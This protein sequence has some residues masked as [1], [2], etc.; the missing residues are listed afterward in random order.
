MVVDFLIIPYMAILAAEAGGS[1]W[2]AHY[3]N[4]KGATGDDG[5]D[6]GGVMPFDLTWLPE[7]FFSLGFVYALWPLVGWW[8]LIALPWCY[9]WMQTGHANA[10]PW[11]RGGHDPDRTNTLSPI[12]KWLCDA[13]NIKYYG[14]NFARLFMA[15]KGFLITLPVGG[16]SGFIFW[17]LGY[18]I[19]NRI[20]KHV[21]AELFSGAGAGISILLFLI[22]S[23]WCL[24]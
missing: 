1:L 12:V 22:I 17:P 16:F 21:Y 20:G 6:L 5:R 9:I 18:E 10:L 4:K 7:F 15:V 23:E 19:G 8:S 2:V 3:L 14:V 24:S 11:G 13:F